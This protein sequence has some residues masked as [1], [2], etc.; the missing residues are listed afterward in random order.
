[1]RKPDIYVYLDDFKRDKVFV[2]TAALVLAD[3]AASLLED[4]DTLRQDIKR[5]LIEQYPGAAAHPKLG[6]H[7]LPEIHAVDLFQS[8][9]YY[10]K[11][12]VSPG[13]LYWKRHHD[14]LEEALK[15]VQKHDIRFVVVPIA[16]TDLLDP[17]NQGE[18]PISKTLSIV[19]SPRIRSELDRLYCNPYVH[20]LPTMLVGLHRPF[21]DFGLLGEVICDDQDECKGFEVIASI[22]WLRKSGQF[23][24]LSSPRFASSLDEALI[25]VSDVAG[26]VFGRWFH[27]SQTG[28][29]LKAELQEWFE[30]Y[31]HERCRIVNIDQ[32]DTQQ[33]DQVSLWVFSL[34]IEQT[35]RNA[36]LKGY[37]YETLRKLFGDL[38]KGD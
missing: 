13:D 29:I 4:W 32:F 23:T 31:I 18:P 34:L 30:K 21:A 37:L 14:W 19:Q 9:G 15:V 11:T 10:R 36:E 7:Q 28:L 2:L 8:G 20:A 1:M 22:E 35:I 17:R 26:Y 5:V 24:H 6:G 38:L 12:S 16:N 25:Q 3:K 33:R 27:A